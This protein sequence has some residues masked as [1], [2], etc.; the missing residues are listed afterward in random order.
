M[1]HDVDSYGFLYLQGMQGG[2]LGKGFSHPE[3]T[4]YIFTFGEEMPSV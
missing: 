1:I 3:G 2:N 4:L